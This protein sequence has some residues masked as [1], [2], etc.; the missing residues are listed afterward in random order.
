MSNNSD[1]FKYKTLND[2]DFKNIDAYFEETSHN[3]ALYQEIE[4]CHEFNATLTHFEIGIMNK[5]IRREQAWEMSWGVAI[6][7]ELKAYR[8]KE[9]EE[10]QREADELHD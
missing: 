6:P 4:N 7:P 2:D 3:S 8:K 9:M 1:S 10:I 5:Q